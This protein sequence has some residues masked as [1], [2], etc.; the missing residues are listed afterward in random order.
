MLVA[1]PLPMPLPT[2][3]GQV[4]EEDHLLERMAAGDALAMAP[5]YDLLASR[6][7]ALALRIT[8]DPDIAQDVVQE[9]FVGTWS[10]AA[11][12]DADRGSGRTWFLSIVHHRAIDAL[13]RRRGPTVQLPEPGDGM[14]TPAVLAAP[15]PWPEVSERLDR[16]LVLDALR[17]LP[18]AQRVAIELAYFQGLSQGEIAVVTSAPLGTVKSRVR[19]GLLALRADLVRLGH[20]PATGMTERGVPQRPARIRRGAASRPSAPRTGRGT[21]CWPRAAAPASRGAPATFPTEG[22]RTRTGGAHPSRS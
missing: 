2:P 4:P 5:F 15:D 22:S 3:D 16:A 11:S 7:Y 17:R 14:P 19:L 10:R 9:S 8:R 13:R 20:G 12:W 1:E 18:D 6:A 21:A